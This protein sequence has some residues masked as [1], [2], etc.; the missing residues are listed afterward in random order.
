LPYYKNDSTTWVAECVYTEPEKLPTNA[1][2]SMNIMAAREGRYNFARLWQHL[3]R[4]EDTTQSP[5]V[6]EEG[7]R[8]GAFALTLYSLVSLIYT[9][10]LPPLLTAIGI[11]PVYMFSQ[12]LFAFCMLATN[13][14]ASIAPSSVPPRQTTPTAA[15]TTPA[16]ILAIVLIA[17]CGISWATSMVVP[18]SLIGNYVNQG[19]DGG[20]ILGIHNI[21]IVVPQIVTTILSSLVFTVSGGPAGLQFVLTFAGLSAIVSAIWVHMLKDS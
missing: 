14:V 15:P 18:F 17:T 5:A 7:V 21:F 6:P 16:E 19:E 3:P 4:V 11:K 13:I 8:M 10:I 9:C 12:G 1:F 2:L 20:L